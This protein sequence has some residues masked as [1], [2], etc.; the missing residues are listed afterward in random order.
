ME[1]TLAVGG[2][3]DALHPDF[4]DVGIFAAA[5]AV[6]GFYLECWAAG[7][8]AGKVYF[9]EVLPECYLDFLLVFVLDLGI[10]G[11]DEGNLEIVHRI[12]P[13]KCQNLYQTIHTRGAKLSKIN[14]LNIL[15]H[16]EHNLLLF[17]LS[18]SFHCRNLLQF[19]LI[20]LCKTLTST[21]IFLIAIIFCDGN[22]TELVIYGHFLETI[23]E[24]ELVMFAEGF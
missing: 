24:V 1:E 12:A 15:G 19:F 23:G 9:V 7:V 8:E 16:S 18:L 3:G 17:S 20:I 11:W 4:E 21:R 22:I 5:D 6:D 13:T 2:V 10:L 14:N